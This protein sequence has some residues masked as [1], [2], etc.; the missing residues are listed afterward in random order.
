MVARRALGIRGMVSYAIITRLRRTAIA[1]AIASAAMLAA[2]LATRVRPAGPAPREIAGAID[3]NGWIAGAS[4]G[5]YTFA[6]PAGG[7]AQVAIN[8]RIVSNGASATPVHLD[9]SPR[10]FDFQDRRADASHL[11][12][13]W[14]REG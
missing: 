4:E 1:V 5:M 6:V 8:G 9:P 13:T 11:D 10:A 7:G 2:T 14:S 3:W 12:V